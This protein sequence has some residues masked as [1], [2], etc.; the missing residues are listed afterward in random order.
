MRRTASFLLAPMSLLPL[1]AMLALGL[2]PR[3]LPAAVVDALDRPALPARDAAHAVLLAAASAGP[4]IVAVGERGIVV[5]SDDDGKSWRQARVPVS[6]TLTAL[7]FAD[8]KNGFAVGHGGT[9]LATTDGGQTWTR[10]LDGRRIAAL[11]RQAAQASGDAAALQEAQRLHDDG[12]DKPLLDLWVFDARRVLVVGAYGLAFE[13]GD[14]G[15]TWTPWM[16]RLPNP[17]GLHLYSVRAQGESLLLA[18]EQGLVLH[19]ADGGAHWQSLTLPYK[20]SFFTAEMPAART[21]V[22][23]G[24][25]GNAWRTQDGGATWQALSVAL[26][27]SITGS[28]LGPAGALWFVNQAGFVMAARAGVLVPLHRAPLPP[29]N[30]LLALA[31]G[32]LLALSVQGVLPVAAAKEDAR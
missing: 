14:G 20:G 15:Q 23:A 8:A 32:R 22:V 31:N 17:K 6:V 26:P 25:R 24:L 28:A 5:L 19:S 3:D 7:R 4:R 11:A 2:A 30:G 27:V 1:L 12:P 10:R 18:G 29:L 13:T 16:A 21:W 9:V